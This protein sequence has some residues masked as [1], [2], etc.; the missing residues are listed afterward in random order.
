MLFYDHISVLKVYFHFQCLYISLTHNTIIKHDMLLSTMA[1]GWRGGASL[2]YTW[3]TGV[4]NG[5]SHAGTNNNGR[6]GN[7]AYQICK[8]SSWG[9]T[10]YVR[11][12]TRADTAVDWST[13][14]AP[15]ISSTRPCAP[16]PP[17]PHYRLLSGVNFQSLSASVVFIKTVVF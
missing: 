2:H 5:V 7:T 4:R 16:P 6:G 15:S 3:H 14:A 9:G 17:P 1:G 13:D 11:W 8:R 10:H 12:N